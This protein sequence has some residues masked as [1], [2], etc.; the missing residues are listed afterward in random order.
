MEGWIRN[1]ADFDEEFELQVKPTTEST[2]SVLNGNH[3]HQPLIANV[4]FGIFSG[5]VDSVRK[6]I[7][8]Y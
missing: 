6:T 7:I 3:E 4:H 8:G 5:T 1:R 2:T